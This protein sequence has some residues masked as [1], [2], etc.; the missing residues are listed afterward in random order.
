MTGLCT[1]FIVNSVGINR[2]RSPREVVI[3]NT[4]SGTR[5][6]RLNKD[7]ALVIRIWA[8]RLCYKLFC[9]EQMCKLSSKV[10][11]SNMY[12]LSMKELMS[13]ENVNN[14][15]RNFNCRYG[16]FINDYHRKRLNT[17]TSS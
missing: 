17:C 16:A 11:C 10:T 13:K 8:C 2:S 12:A 6:Y 3:N 1:R 5:R 14:E 4:S 7:I 9:G 15:I